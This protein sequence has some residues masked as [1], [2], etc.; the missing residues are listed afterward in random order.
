M[1]RILVGEYGLSDEWN[2]TAKMQRKTA[3]T[4]LKMAFGKR[5]GYRQTWWWNEEVQQSTKEK[6]EAKKAWD[7]IRN[8]NNKKIYKVKK[9]TAKKSVAMAKELRIK[10][11]NKIGNKMQDWKQK[12]VTRC[13]TDW[14]ARQRDIARIDVQHVRVMKDENG[15]VMISSEVVLMKWKEYFEKLINEEKDR[16]P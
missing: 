14:L 8:E 6:K 4:T 16:K 7:K 1:T 9:S 11:G 10:I 12:K 2:K 3:K 15:N 5:K 13:C